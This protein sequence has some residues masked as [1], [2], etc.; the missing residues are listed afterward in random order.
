MALFQKYTRRFFKLLLC[1]CMVT[2]CCIFNGLSQN[3]G[4]DSTPI[5]EQTVYFGWSERKPKKELQPYYKALKTLEYSEKRLNVIEKLIESHIKKSNTDSVL[6]YANLYKKDINSLNLTKNKQQPYFAKAHFY[7]GK[8]NF[9]NGLFD[10]AIKW[11]IKGI[12]EAENSDFAKF[13]YK[14]KLG[15][16]NCYITQFETDKAI[17]ILKETRIDFPK[18]D[19]HIITTNYI[20]L[21]KAYRFKKEYDSSLVYYN[22]AL[23]L[24]DSIQ[25][26]ELQLKSR[27]GLAK[28]TDAQGEL[29][30]AFQAYERIRN[31]AKSEG[32]D[33]IFFEGSLLAARTF[34]KQEFYDTAVIAL[35]MAYI[36]AIDSNNLHYQ[37]ELLIIQSRCFYKKGDYKNAYNGMTQLFG[38]ASQIQSKQQQDIIKELEIQ[39]ETL[40]KEQAIS[41]L[42]E[43]QLKKEAELD[44]Q[45]TIRN[46]F[47][48][49]F[50]V[51][52]IP[53]IALLYTYF[54]KI[55]AQSLLNKKQEEI[56]NQKVTALKQE[57]ELN[58]I[59]ATIEGQDEE[60]KR[61]A[62][63]LHD[64]IGGNLAGIKLQ[65]SSI[66]NMP[67]RLHTI[68][69]Q[70]N[71]TY[72]LVRDISHTLT[73]KKFRQ[74][75]FTT[76]VCEYIK[77][78]NNAGK[79]AINFYPHPEPQINSID[80]K[81]HVE[82]F[83]IIQEL[84]TNT[85]KH[86][87]ANKL[88][89]HLNLIDNTL[90]LLFE[91]NGIGFDT[92]IM[93]Q[94]IGLTNIQDRITQINGHLHIDTALNR[95]TVIAVEIP[96]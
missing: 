55:Q 62:Q 48:I 61:I 5:T 73:P 87:Q 66:E 68:S 1:N 91:D 83:K 32:L 84:M 88:D 63:E 29:E 19:S 64:S 93:K 74:N 13:N 38:V 80:D 39:Y 92:N 76:L 31:E 10:N 41:E 16:A 94:G 47:L 30:T 60:R 54:Q 75:K 4:K 72:Q 43:N 86:A 34:Y 49:G 51:I 82:V 57:Q 37:K 26:K 67:E 89:I 70:L 33:A 12:Q 18:A 96:I 79:I 65:L 42:K 15:L 53:I 50:I 17:A 11:H 46:A 85:L 77:G 56:N 23:K 44:R 6:H 9:M 81:I 2:L 22:K 25:I 27:I 8:G 21:G 52:L 14:N 24:S 36:N 90:S 78:I 40:K 69:S 7:L 58:L 71:E 28:L 20:L 59:K 35:S 45:K 95:G 3:S